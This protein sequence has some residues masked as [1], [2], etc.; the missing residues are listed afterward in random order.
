M[1]QTHNYKLVCKRILFQ[2]FNRKI[3]LVCVSPGIDVGQ[4][5]CL[6]FYYKLRDAPCS[7]SL[8]LC[9]YSLLF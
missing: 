2:R 6:K 5:I 1:K 7:V 4:T 9:S 8:L 3:G